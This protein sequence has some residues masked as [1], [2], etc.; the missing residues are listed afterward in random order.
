MGT[1]EAFPKEFTREDFLGNETSKL[2]PDGWTDV[3]DDGGEK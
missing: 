2:T 3:M 1:A